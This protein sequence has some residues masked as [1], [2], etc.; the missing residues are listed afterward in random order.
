MTHLLC[1]SAAKIYIVSGTEDM[2][3]HKRGVGDMEDHIQ[4]GGGKD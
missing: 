4:S 1:T 2:Y 3:P